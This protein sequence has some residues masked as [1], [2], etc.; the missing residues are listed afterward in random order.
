MKTGYLIAAAGSLFAL[1]NPGNFPLVLAGIFV[2]SIGSIPG[3]LS[4][5]LLSD[6]MDDFERD[7]GY[8]CDAFSVTMTTILGMMGSG[9]AQSIILSGTHL[10][11]YIAPSSSTDIIVQSAAVKGFFNFSLNG[12]ALIGFLASF[13]IVTALDKKRS[14]A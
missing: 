5:S 12:I 4:M 9:I 11:G 2:K 1:M 6:V 10:T 8:R 13:L 7:H 3:F 14:E